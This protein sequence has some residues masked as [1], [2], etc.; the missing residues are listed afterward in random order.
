M[1][2]LKVVTTGSVLVLLA[3]GGGDGGSTNPP[4]SSAL[5]N[6]VLTPTTLALSAGQSQAV[7]ASGRTAAGGTASGVTL[8]YASSSSSVASVSAA[9]LVLGLSQGSSTITVTGT[10][11]AVTKSA[12][13][14]V[15]V[16]GALPN[17]VTVVAGSATTDFTP[18]SVAIARA[19][20]VTWTFG[21]LIHN[22]EFQGGT[23]AP[24]NIP[25]S[26]NLSVARTFAT[27]GTF[28]YLCSLH[29][30]MNGTIQVQ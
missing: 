20:T 13:A 4:L 14:Q 8:T 11:G 19:G 28:N 17:A 29:S 15:T 27:A 7:T 12:T 2:A 21:V 5:D 16:S 23:G 26:S 25:N 10:Q 6:L 30:G 22:V 24:S 18:A 3:C 1:M 9:G